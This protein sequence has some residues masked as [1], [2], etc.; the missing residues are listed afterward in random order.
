[1]KSADVIGRIG[2]FIGDGIIEHL[3]EHKNI[4]R[5]DY[6]SVLPGFLEDFE[7]ETLMKALE[8]LIECAADDSFP[9]KSHLYIAIG[10]LIYSSA[11]SRE[12]TAEL[13]EML[14]DNLR[15]SYAYSIIE[16][17]SYLASSQQSSMNVQAEILMLF[18]SLLDQK[19][20]D[21]LSHMKETPDGPVY[22]LSYETT[23]Y[24]ELIPRV[25]KGLKNLAIAPASESSI[26]ERILDRLLLLWDDLAEYRIIWGSQNVVDLA[27]YLMNI[28]MSEK[29]EQKRKMAIIDA[30]MKR[31][32]VLTVMEYLGNLI[33][34]VD[35]TEKIAIQLVELFKNLEERLLDDEFL[36]I[37]ERNMII[38]TMLKIAKR[39]RI[40]KTDKEAESIR[41]LITNYAFESIREGFIKLA[42]PLIELMKSEHISAELEDEIHTRL[43]RFK[44]LTD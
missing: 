10:K 5:K 28:G 9:D 7:R 12:K 41:N 8:K 11:P 38:R 14:L 43:K 42:D 2:E 24:T 33:A 6:D 31:V 25:M 4:A 30:L 13:S 23:A 1:L 37:E 35:E 20:P 19:Y 3:R 27:K 34:E 26:T 39:R 44:I 17:L 29:I 32:T 22:E 16:A 40:G 18:L 21:V 36:E 15:S